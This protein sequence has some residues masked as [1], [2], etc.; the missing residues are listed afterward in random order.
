MYI[1]QH[2]ITEPTTVGILKYRF[3]FQFVCSFGSS[4]L[5]KVFQLNK[6]SIDTF[7]DDDDDYATKITGPTH[8]ILKDLFN[9]SVHFLIALQRKMVI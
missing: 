9:L 6:C 5:I 3:N 1:L 4:I 8:E 7:D 2:K